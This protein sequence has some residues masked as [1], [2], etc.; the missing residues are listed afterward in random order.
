MLGLCKGKNQESA[1]QL[2]SFMCGWSSST[3][4]SCLIWGKQLIHKWL[5]V[6]GWRER[7]QFPVYHSKVDILITKW[8]KI[9]QL[10]TFLV[11][12]CWGGHWSEVSL[13]WID[14]WSRSPADIDMFGRGSALAELCDLGVLLRSSLEISGKLK[15]GDKYFNSVSS[16]TVMLAL[17]SNSV[18]FN[19]QLI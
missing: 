12:V 18:S 11:G 14:I 16:A 6:Q 7:N 4:W 15:S 10:V 5:Q 9:S 19:F 8:S 17:S 3:G 13:T 1:L 2:F